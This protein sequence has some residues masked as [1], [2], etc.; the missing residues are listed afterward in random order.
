MAGPNARFISRAYVNDQKVELKDH[1]IVLNDSAPGTCQINVR[2]RA[3]K[4][5]TVKVDL[6]WGDMVDR[7]F[8]GYV[9]RVLPSV[10]G[11]FTLFCREWSSA[12]MFN[13][14]V[15][16]RHATMRQVLNEI[17]NQT[18]IEFVIPDKP[19]SESAAP[20]FY[21]DGSGLSML[22]NIGRIYKISDFIWYQQGNGKVFVGSYADSF[23][24]DKPVTIASSLMTEHQ[25]GKSAMMPAAPMVRPHVMANNE[26]LSKVE[27]KE[28][29][30]TL[31]W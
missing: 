11:W 27:F 15:M 24:S 1:W 17:S 4:L 18:G 3:T 6:G 26:R 30:M 21:S 19:Y 20:C 23:W 12:L 5:D 7:V 28:T 13:L 8:N 31:S 10:N 9:E 29:N 2:Q 22:D 16:L 14:S 25:A